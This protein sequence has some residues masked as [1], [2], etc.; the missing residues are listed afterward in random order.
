MKWLLWTIVTVCT[1]YIGAAQTGVPQKSPKSYVDYR[2]GLTQVAIQYSSPAVRG[3]TIWGGLVP[4][5]KVW[6]AGANHATTVNFNTPVVIGGK[7]LQAGEY[8]LFL[9]PKKEGRWTAIF[10]HDAD[11]WGAFLYKEADDAVRIDVRVVDNPELVERLRYHIEDLSLE[12]GLIVMSWEHK[13]VSIPFYVNTIAPALANY[14]T[15]INTMAESE[16][17]YFLAEEAD[18]LHEIGRRSEAD[19][20]IQESLDG[21]EHV[22]NLW[23][24]ARFQASRGNYEEAYATV[25]KMKVL[26]D[27]GIEEE[28]Q[29]YSNLEAEINEGMQTWKADQ[30]RLLEINKDIW[31]PFS[32]AYASGDADKYL[33]LHSKDFVRASKSGDNTTDL[34]GY[35]KSVLRSFNRNA[36]NG[37]KATIE[38]RFFERFASS[39]TASER[40]IYKY[41]YY[42]LNGTPSSGYGKFH[43]VS[44]KEDGIWKILMDYDSDENKTIDEDDFEAAFAAHD[45]RKFD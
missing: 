42:P 34:D 14:D 40:G 32:E 3:R 25:G 37:S 5:D 20:K 12:E 7:Q 30:N 10:N 13:R 45:I 2:V 6:R 26:A 17:W 38:F 24:K 23:K 33:A 16:R 43:V 18:M 27:S 41:T 9:I 39:S 8:A 15:L 31:T 1:T 4:Y 36:I 11:Q 19:G 44:R 28:S 22:W 35:S 29:T 21:G